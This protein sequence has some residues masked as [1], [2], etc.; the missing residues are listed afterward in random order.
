M[1]L[2]FPLCSLAALGIAALGIAALGISAPA[3]GQQTG[4][5][6]STPTAS[7]SLPPAPTAPV[8]SGDSA[9]RSGRAK[10]Y[11]ARGEAALAAGM[12]DTAKVAFEKALYED[13]ACTDAALG[14]ATILTEDGDGLH[15]RDLI[16]RA[17]QLDPTNPKVQHFSA[18]RR[19][20]P[21]DSTPQ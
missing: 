7:V 17:L 1:R 10:I 2:R 9:A 11:A 5:A 16:A 3:G 19:G 14:L 13:Y 12:R 20:A 18:H 4:T 21:R 15:A 8:G 6:P